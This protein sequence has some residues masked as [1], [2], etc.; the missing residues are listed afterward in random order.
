MNEDEIKAQAKK[1]MDEFIKALEKV[2]VE[3]KVGFDADSDT[4]VPKAKKNPDFRKELLENAP[5]SKDGCILAEKKK[6]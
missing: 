1:I 4:R 2:N 5:N 3:E 6:W